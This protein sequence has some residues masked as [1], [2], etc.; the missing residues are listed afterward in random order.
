MRTSVFASNLVDL[1][2]SVVRCWES[3]GER[4]PHNIAAYLEP[5]QR[6]LTI[7]GG[8]CQVYQYSTMCIILITNKRYGAM[9]FVPH[10][11]WQ[12]WLVE[13]IPATLPLWNLSTM[14]SWHKKLGWII[15]ANVSS[16]PIRR[17]N[18]AI[19]LHCCQTMPYLWQ[20]ENQELWQSILR[21]SASGSFHLYFYSYLFLFVSVDL[22]RDFPFPA[23]GRMEVCVHVAPRIRCGVCSAASQ[24][25]KMDF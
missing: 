8:N 1:L 4:R 6:T 11:A 25:E 17:H 16:Q 24:N 5:P 18:F 15:N 3:Q 7:V 10:P 2:C 14:K 21:F 13:H 9:Y 20:P 12:W 23:S 19:C 22:D